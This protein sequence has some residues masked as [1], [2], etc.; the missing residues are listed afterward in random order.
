MMQKNIVILAF[1]FGLK[2]IGVAIGQNI[3]KTASPLPLLKAR[4]G[5]PDW[6]NIKMLLDEWKPEKVIVGFPLNMDQSESE[7]A[8]RAK[9]FANRIHGRFSISV[10]LF[11]ERLST[12]EAKDI[13]KELGHKGDYK[14]NP[15][16]AIAACL[17]LESYWRNH[18]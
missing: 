8:L 5:I 16:D 12:F 4:D 17:I 11:D 9:K 3:T 13:A 2:N 18:T 15:I 6:N 10:E 7:L 1:D 14:N